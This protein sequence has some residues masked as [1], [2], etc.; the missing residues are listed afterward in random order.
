MKVLITHLSDI[1]LRRENNSILEKKGKICQAIQN[2]ALEFDKLFAV[3][4]GDIAY[5]GV[6]EE[7]GQA[8]DLL[9]AIRNS[10]KDYSG[11]EI[12]YIIIPGNHDCNYE[13]KSK[14][15]RKI[16][17]DNIQHSD[18]RIDETII[19]QCCE[20]QNAFFDFLEK[21]HDAGNVL[22]SDKLLRI[23]EYEIGEF[24]IIFTC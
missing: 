9:N 3:I 8:A 15:I 21:Y 22:H 19:D 10:V 17:I 6:E 7:Y 18:G 23:Y 5:S 14:E 16:L 2:P 4:S 24:D 20:V 13:I 1:H 11:K 12:S